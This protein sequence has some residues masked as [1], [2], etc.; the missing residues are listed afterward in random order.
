M[1]TRSNQPHKPQTT[2]GVPLFHVTVFFFIEKFL[3]S[4]EVDYTFKH[5]LIE[6]VAITFQ[7]E[8]RDRHGAR[9]M[10]G[11]G[12]VPERSFVWRFIF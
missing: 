3:A 4:F 11:L 7:P 6:P 5:G 1:S 2:M 10:P 9:H 12:F 8:W